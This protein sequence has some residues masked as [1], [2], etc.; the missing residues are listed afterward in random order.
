MA[1]LLDPITSRDF[2]RG[3][4]AKSA[5]ATSLVPPNS[6]ANALNMD[7]SEIIGSP[8]VRKGNSL[9]SKI[10]VSPNT[11]GQ[12]QQA[13]ADVLS[14]VGGVNWFAQTFT[15]IAGEETITG[16]DLKFKRAGTP[17]PITISL[18]AT[19]AGLPTGPDLVHSID[20]S[21]AAITTGAG[22]DVVTFPTLPITVV[23]GT[24]YAIVVRCTGGSGGN[25]LAWF[26][27]AA[28]GYAGGQATFST[29]SGSTWTADT[30][31]DFY[32]VVQVLNG[33]NAYN[34][35]PRGF[36]SGVI[37]GVDTMNVVYE[38]PF[39]STSFVY[40]WI[41]ATSEFTLS[42]LQSGVGV[43][44]RFAILKGAVFIVSTNAV[45]QYSTDRGLIWQQGSSNN[46]TITQDGVKPDLVWVSKNRMLASGYATFGSRVY[47]SS[48]VQP[49]SS[50]FI[51]WNT[52]P[53]TGDWID[54]NPDDGGVVTGFSDTSSIVLIF[55]T[56]AMYRLN[57]I[58]KTVDTDNIFNVGAT[59]QEAITKCLGLTYF[60]SGNG[61]YRTDG[62]FPELISRIAV[63]DFLDA[64]TAS[65]KA[66]AKMGTDGFNVYFS[67]GTTTI[68]EDDNESRTYT[69]VVLKFSPR[70][71]NWSIYSYSQ[72]Q[73]NFVQYLNNGGQPILLSAQF[74]GE[75]DQLNVGTGDYGL[76]VPYELETQDQE[77]G[78][79]SHTKKISDQIIVY[80][81][82][83]GKSSLLVKENDG[84]FKPANMK[85]NQAVNVGNNVN[86][87]GE[88]F[89]F[90]LNGSAVGFRPVFQGYHLPKVTD[91]GISKQ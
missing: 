41:A 18:R 7:F 20:Y 6:V 81:E 51:T 59:N 69:N 77:F 36:M 42:N 40:T 34:T 33:A 58:N 49:N 89:T 63:Q 82:N 78:N 54:I 14:L 73:G 28:G 91:E 87:E 50:N 70:D 57:A 75:I 68:I 39:F 66:F 30:G 10:V 45:M 15:P 83:G 67:I 31:T 60:Y 71:E 37:A 1:Q 52:D 35:Q 11:F 55:K 56:N 72:R 90:R 8:I 22:G 76:E 61:I 43:K 38:N 88:F 4:I 21:T 13:G 3:R 19:A 86:F 47:F 12:N 29:N 46:I 32:F 79:R 23:P 44:A 84:D 9:F 25:T 26:K 24:T 2:S 27:N 85:L 62:G 48:I 80:M 74:N 65:Q 5:V 16:F 17:G 53:D 64:M